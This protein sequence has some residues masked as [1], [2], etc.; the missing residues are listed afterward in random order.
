MYLIIPATFFVPVYYIEKD[1]LNIENTIPFSYNEN[2]T[3]EYFKRKEL[4]IGVSLPTLKENRWIID[5]EIM[6]TYAKN[7]GINLKIEI[8][9]FDANKQASQVENLISQGI[10]VL[11]LAPVD[12]VAAADLIEK[13]NKAGIKVISYE[14]LAKNSNVDLYIAFDNSKVGELQG[15]FLTEKVPK[16][17]YIVLS[18][19]PNVGLKESAMK[20]IKPLID[21]GNIKIVTDKTIKL[22][23]PA[24][25][26]D[27][28]KN[29]LINNNNKVDA[30]LAPNDTSAGAA[31][32]A[33]K[34]YGL[35]GKVVV[36]GQNANLPAVKRIL[37]RTQAMT[38]FKD[39][40]ELAKTAMDAA[41]KLANNQDLAINTYIN[42]GKINVPSIIL[43]PIVVDS[44]NVNDVIIKSGYYN[45]NE[46]YGS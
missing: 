7:K 27:I 38:V 26:Y 46:V 2:I 8:N 11:I 10:D 29:A 33:L 41:V 21:I 3:N 30:I 34:E 24:T 4:V 35:D 22:S 36:T 31:I 18:T 1:I 42:N 15:K 17:N 12:P 13:A 23:N 19:D 5:K 6:E 25:T 37:Q 43:T 40:R 39:N 14:I 44:K 28:V 16:G 20:Y 9:D 32:E 45:F